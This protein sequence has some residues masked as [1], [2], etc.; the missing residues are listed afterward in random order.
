MG[1]GTM[2]LGAA[3]LGA[4]AAFD[5][6]SDTF[7]KEPTNESEYKTI[8]ESYTSSSPTEAKITP[9]E[10]ES[11]QIE[12]KILDSQ[13]TSEDLQ[14]PVTVASSYQGDREDLMS[15]KSPVSDKIVREEFHQTDIPIESV[16]SEQQ[17][18]KKLSDDETRYEIVESEQ[19]EY[20]EEQ[21]THIDR[22]IS[23]ALRHHE[24]KKSD[25]FVIESE[26]VEYEKEE[27]THIDRPI[28][29]ALKHHEDKKSDE[30]V[31]ESGDVL[32]G[33]F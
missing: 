14:S 2:I 13:I 1:L 8:D 28:S 6:I 25:E 17:A 26:P 9:V 31:I 20:K 22:P 5:K 11:S 7:Q 15:Q 16:P 10:E 27:E 19:V 23:D 4:K 12:S 29:E 18:H 21:T 24:D 33:M 30:F 3:A 32:S